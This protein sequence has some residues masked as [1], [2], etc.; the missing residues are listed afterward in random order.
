MKASWKASK[1]REIADEFYFAAPAGLIGAEE[2]PVGCGLIEVLPNR[3]TRRVVKAE[4]S[5]G[6]RTP[7]LVAAV[8]RAVAREMEARP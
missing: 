8:A 6:P 3:K 4:R 2:L 1:G 5:R 7:E